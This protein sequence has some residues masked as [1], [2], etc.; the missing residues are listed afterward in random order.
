MCVCMNCFKQLIY[1]DVG[2]IGLFVFELCYLLE[3]QFLI[4]SFNVLILVL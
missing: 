2:I 3:N 1:K 4:T